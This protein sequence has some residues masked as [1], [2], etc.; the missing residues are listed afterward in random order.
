LRIDSLFFGV[1]ISYFANFHAAQFIRIAERFAMRFILIGCLLLVPAFIYELEQAWVISTFGFSVF[2]L[3]SGMIL[4]GMLGCKPF[5][6]RRW[7]FIALVGR[8]SYSIYLWHYM[9]RYLLILYIF[10]FFGMSWFNDWFAYALVYFV[11]SLLIGIGLGRL[12]ETPMLRFRE[13][14]YPSRRREG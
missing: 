13:R 8:Q 5:D 14:Y 6:S 12:I 1:F 9:Y 7:S 10:P 3:G 4:V 11:G 2:Y